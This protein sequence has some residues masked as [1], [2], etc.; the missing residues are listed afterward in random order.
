MSAPYSADELRSIYS[1]MTLIREFEDCV[2]RL[3]LDGKLVGAIH[4]YAGQ[5]SVAVGVCLH[6][7]DDDYIT[8]THRPHGHCLAKGVDPGAMMAELYGKSNGLCRGKGGSMHLGDL[9]RGVLGANGIVGA[10]APLACG[11]A[12]SAKFSGAAR[13][14]V[15]FLG[16]GATNAGAFHEA[17]NLASVLKLPVVFVIENNGYADATHIRY[18]AAIENLADRAR[19]YGMPGLTIDGTDVFAVA[20]AAGQAVSRARAEGLPYVLEC[21]TYRYYGHY[22]GDAGGYRSQ[23][24]IE[25]ARARDC[26]RHFEQTVIASGWLTGDELRHIRARSLDAVEKA[27]EFAEAGPLPQPE[28]CLEDLFAG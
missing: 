12:L 13:V 26:I 19:A 16:D 23:E 2:Q 22:S 14:A 28:A 8:S 17:L 6:L 11:A 27:V 7:R 25:A 20:A 21:K 24:E 1:R 4:L 18:A 5:E 9:S 3:F 10:G 15:C